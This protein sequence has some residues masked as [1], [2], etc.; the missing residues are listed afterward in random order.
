VLSFIA[1]RLVYIFVALLPRL[2]LGS[3]GFAVKVRSLWRLCRS[4]DSVIIQIRIS[5][6]CIDHSLA[7]GQYTP[8]VTSPLRLS[9]PAGQSSY[10][11][12]SSLIGI[13]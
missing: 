10:V 13:V 7:V 12:P 8:A 1:K 11:F 6:K 9:A 4:R 2:L 5:S 3:E